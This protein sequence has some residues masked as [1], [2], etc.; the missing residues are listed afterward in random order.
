[1]EEDIA[2]LKAA[3]E[4]SRASKSTRVRYHHPRIHL[5]LPKICRGKVKEIDDLLNYIQ[6][7]DVSVETADAWSPSSHTG[8]LM[9]EDV[10]GGMVP[11]NFS[12]LSSTV[13]VDCTILLAIVSD[14][15]NTHVIKEPWLHTAAKRQ[16]EMEEEQNLLPSVLFPVMGNHTLVCTYEAATR[17]QEIVNTIGTRSEMARTEALLSTSNLSHGDR[18]TKYARL[19]NHIIPPDWQLPV[20][21]INDFNPLTPELPSIANV[22]SGEL[23]DLNRSVFLFGWQKGYTTI[24]SNR[25]TAKRIQTLIEES[26]VPGTN[27]VLGP[28]IWVCQTARS[29]RAKDKIRGLAVPR[30]ESNLGFGQGY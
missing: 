5:V 18:L 9:I 10:V 8:C 2:I 15:S 28:D 19:S 25:T 23:S 11:G 3:E 12:C 16:I 17:M 6:G 13:N 1:M 30:N 20:Q 22:V 21:V 4:L 24:T 29:L 14:L 26:L 27:D 7:L